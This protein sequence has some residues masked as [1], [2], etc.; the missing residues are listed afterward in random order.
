M[1]PVK[2]KCLSI[3]DKKKVIAAVEAGEKKQML[4]YVL[5]PQI[6]K[7]VRGWLEKFKKRHDL[8][9]KK[10]CGESASVD[11][12]NSQD[13]KN[14]LIDL[15]VDYDA[16]DIFNSDETG[17]FYKCLPD[18]TLTFKNEKCHGSKNSKERITVVLAANMDGSQKLK[19][20]M[21]GKFAN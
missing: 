19:P 16:R 17:L 15:L 12:C 14:E 13:L 1:G 10:V 7:L 20:L 5:V 6:F 3:T 11:P 9:F 2:Y 21:I 4:L 18:R 8:T